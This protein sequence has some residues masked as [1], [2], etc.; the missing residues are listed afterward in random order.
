M[1]DV[2]AS[3]SLQSG[4]SDDKNWKCLFWF[5][6]DVWLKRNSFGHYF[7][8]GNRFCHHFLLP[9]YPLIVILHVTYGSFPNFCCFFLS[10]A[11]PRL[12]F[13]DFWIKPT[14]QLDKGLKAFYLA[15]D[16]HLGSM[17]FRWTKSWSWW[18][19]SEF[20]ERKTSLKH[21]KT[22]SNWRGFV[23]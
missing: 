23:S 18:Y 5:Q 13:C 8:S 1:S 12:F 3:M 9:N 4:G 14:A 7:G 10:P 11:N 20:F 15:D 22:E 6:K 21:N 16:K 2:I 19:F 17:P